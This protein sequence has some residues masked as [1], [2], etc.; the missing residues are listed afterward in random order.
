MPRLNPAILSLFLLCLGGCA[1][2]VTVQRAQDLSAAGIAYGNAA[3]QLMDQT[4][5]RYIDY[6]SDELLAEIDGINPCTGDELIDESSA[7]PDCRDTISSFD[8]SQQRVGQTASLMTQLGVQAQAMSAYFGALQ[9]LADDGAGA[10]VEASASRLATQLNGLNTA[11]GGAAILTDAQKAAYSGLA[12]FAADAYKAGVL[13]R[14]LSRDAQTISLAIELQDRVIETNISVLKAIGAAEDEEDYLANVR[15]PYLLGE[16]GDASNWKARRKELL[17][18]QNVVSQLESL[19]VAS[20]RLRGI[21]DDIL[22]NRSTL[23]ETQL[24][25][26]DLAKALDLIAAARDANAQSQSHN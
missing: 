4:R 12:G 19:R 3:S 24:L 17:L 26:D 18:R 1:T 22:H 6:N 5:D 14:V 10:A 23:A 2:P 11:L 25:L 7:S 21:W 8:D 16:P 15:H 9:D 20:Q 13:K